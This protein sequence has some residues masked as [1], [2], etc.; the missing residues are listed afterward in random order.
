VLVVDDE[1]AV[2]AATSAILSS[3]GYHVLEADGGASALE[4]LRAS[5]RKIDLVLLD[6]AMPNM[7]GQQTLVELKK[8]RPDLPV[9]LLTAY[10]EDEARLSSIR[11]QLAGFVAKPFAYEE[12]IG[13]VTSAIN[14]QREACP[15]P[16]ANRVQALPSVDRGKAS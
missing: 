10:A 3:V 8:I 7:N 4:Q 1:P 9:V 5:E 12:L 6:L 2:R 11:A 13:A 14:S 15:E 16:K